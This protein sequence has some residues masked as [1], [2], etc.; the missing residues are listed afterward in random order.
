MKSYKEYLPQIDK[1]KISRESLAWSNTWI[2]K[3]SDNNTKRILLVGDSTARMI[4]STM[5]AY[6]NCPVDLIA[7]SYSLHDEMFANLLDG[8]FSTSSNSYDTIFV[9]MGSHNLKT[10][11]GGYLSGR[12]L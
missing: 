9:Q 12:G 4:R 5:S 2:D 11:G 7:S 8:F 1:E 6:L 10:F 3:V